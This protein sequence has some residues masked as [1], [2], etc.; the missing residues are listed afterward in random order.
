MN[1]AV[2]TYVLLRDGGCVARFVNS[3]F[4]ATR[5]PMLQGLPDP[6]PCRSK[7]GDRQNPEALYAMTVDHV[8][9]DG[10]MSFASKPPDDPEHL[11][12]SCWGHHLGNWVNKEPVRAAARLYIP[13]A[14]A[15]AARRGFPPYPALE[16]TGA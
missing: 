15:H 16:Q 10:E 3:A 4:F 1:E 12:T 8:E 14:N 5:W 9:L 11:W 6:G 13:A 7:W 2:R